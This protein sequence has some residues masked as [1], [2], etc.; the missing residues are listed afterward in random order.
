MELEEFSAQ[1]E[2]FKR[3]AFR[4]EARDRYDVDDE[5]EEFATFLEG[6][7]LRTRTAETDP[8]L[9]LVAAGKAAGRVI[10]R[11]RIVGEP[12]T[13]YTRFEFA[14]YRD[15]IAAGEKVRVVPRTALEDTDQAWAS[16]DFWIFDERLVV[17]LHYDGDGRFLG[18]DQAEEPGPYLEARRRALS[19][20]VDFENFV[21]EFGL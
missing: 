7:D 18:A 9:A 6:K 10:E 8:W 5:R 12:L 4:I 3:S 21:A 16:E 17:V 2:R 1:F 13:D 19:L 15:N 20:A 11:V 14:G